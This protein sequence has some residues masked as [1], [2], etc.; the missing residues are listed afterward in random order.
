M[1]RYLGTGA[2]HQPSILVPVGDADVGFD[3]GVLL[4]G[5]AILSFKDVIGLCPLGFPVATLGLDAVD[6]V[7]LGIVDAFGVGFVMDDRGSSLHSCDRVE[8][9]G[10]HLVLHVDQAQRSL[11]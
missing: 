10:Q 3:V 8:D 11:G 7:A 5:G 4:L 6:D 9:V 1:E 2:D